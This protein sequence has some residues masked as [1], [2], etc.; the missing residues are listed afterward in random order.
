M[1]RMSTERMGKALAQLKTISQEDYA[2]VKGWQP[3]SSR[4]E[5][6]SSKLPTITA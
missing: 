3:S 2:K 5:A 6:S 4:Y 1:S